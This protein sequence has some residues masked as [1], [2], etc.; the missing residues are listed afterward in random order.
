MED[1]RVM[2]KGG[3]PIVGLE[4]TLTGFYD[5]NC[6]SFFHA[7]K[8]QYGLDEVLGVADGGGWA[9]LSGVADSLGQSS[10]KLS[11]EVRGP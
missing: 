4:P 8:V 5:L 7:G 9:A 10:P 2:T 11:L 1:G 3:F 6:V